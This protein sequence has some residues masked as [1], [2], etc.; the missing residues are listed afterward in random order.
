MSRML[1]EFMAAGAA[2]PV[3]YRQLD[4]L[5]EAAAT[6]PAPPRAAGEPLR[7][8]FV[9]Y[10]GGG[11]TGAD[12]RVAEMIRQVRAIFGRDRLE[13]GLVVSGEALPADLQ[14]EVRLEVV[15]DYFPEFIARTI[16]RYHGVIACDGSMFKSNLCCMLS[17]MMGGALGMAAVSGR[18]AV[19]Y[20]AEAGRMEPELTEF[21]AG[22]GERPLILCRNEESRAVLEPLGLRVDGGADT[23][24]TYRAEPA[25]ETARRRAELGIATGPLLVVCPMNPFWWPVRPDL[26]KAM[27]LEAR[28][29]HRE[30]HFGSVLFHP[31][32]ASIRQRYHAYLDALAGAADA[33]QDEHG[34]S[35][36]VLGMDRVDRLA[37][38]ELAGRLAR[39]PGVIASGDAPPAA[40]VG[41]LRAADLLVSSRFH[42]IVASMEAGVPAIGVTM[43]ERIA[44]LLGHGKA[45]RRL[46]RVDA[47][48]LAGQLREA[49]QRAEADR[50]AIGL[51]ARVAVV[52]HLRAMAEMGRRFAE[53][54]RRF[55]PD[56]AVPA[57]DAAWT[58]WLPPLS[59]AQ[60]ELVAR[61]G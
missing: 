57:D 46:L 10:A 5:I 18:L 27:A 17:A 47:P 34:G 40:L 33:W 53:E 37:C 61:H 15:L 30:L 36:L 24:W 1:E 51:Q 48:N 52:D 25:E 9:G 31:D 35:V 56:L 16:A 7:L 45:G 11:N 20:G 28:G 12:I 22:L 50:V 60:R 55:H 41:L 38:D 29:E 32:D 39:R 42:A 2:Y 43:D 6:V 4:A 19:G 44:N 26:A 54:V 3:L 13:I 23:A 8:L 59:E 58:A 14:D 49:M 21:I